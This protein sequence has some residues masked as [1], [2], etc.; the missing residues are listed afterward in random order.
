MDNSSPPKKSLGQH[1]LHDPESLQAMCDAVEVS[2][3][4]TVLEI[5]PGLGT[6]TELLVERARRVIAVELDDKLAAELP[7][8]V[9]ASNLQVAHESILTFDLTALP[10]GY[11]V[12]ANIPS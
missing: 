10:A 9:K 6:L 11:K 1:W 4:D 3:D 5:G 8:R 12:V 2:P 7:G